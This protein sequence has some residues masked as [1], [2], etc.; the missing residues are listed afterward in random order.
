[1]WGLAKSP[2]ARHPHQVRMHAVLDLRAS[3]CIREYP[4]EHPVGFSIN[5]FATISAFDARL[6]LA[7]PFPSLNQRGV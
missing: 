6:S 1:M 2:S 3:F 4:V 5:R 7:R